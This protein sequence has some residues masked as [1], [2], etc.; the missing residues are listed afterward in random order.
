[1]NQYHNKIIITTGDYNGIGA[2]ITVKA[3]NELCLPVD[4]IVII[5]NKELVTGLKKDYEIIDIPVKNLEYGK[6]SKEA[7]EFSFQ[8]LKLACELSP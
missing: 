2:E 8:S 7:G 4:D 1:M 6:L 5:S 3:L